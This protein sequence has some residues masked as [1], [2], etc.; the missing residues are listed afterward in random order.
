MEADVCVAG[1]GPAGLVAALL[2]AR[3]G[4]RVTVLEKHESFLRDFRGDT[5]HPSTLDLLDQLGLGSRA[6]RLPHRKV[7]TLRVTFPEDGTFQLADFGRLRTRHP[8]IMFVPQWGFL[9]LIAAAA[10]EHPNFTLLRSTEAVDVIR[11]DGGVRGIR[12]LGPDGPVTVHARL[13]IAADGRHSVL[14][15]RLGLRP[16]V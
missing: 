13:T 12:A 2:F 16:R 14:R 7:D 1:G 5:L 6:E 9:E 11:G 15:D 3:R 8:Y 4:L 10:A